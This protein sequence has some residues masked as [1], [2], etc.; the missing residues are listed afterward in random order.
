M[1][2]VDLFP[3]SIHQWFLELSDRDPHNN[4]GHVVKSPLASCMG[5]PMRMPS[6]GDVSLFKTCI[7]I[8]SGPVSR[9]RSKHDPGNVPVESRHEVA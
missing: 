6:A 7:N 1:F 9:Y 2:G 8:T 3:G 5:Y 4:P